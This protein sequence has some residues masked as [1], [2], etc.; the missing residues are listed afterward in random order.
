M[1]VCVRV[2]V[3]GCVC[4][5]C[6]CVRVC[7]CVCVCACVCLCAKH[8]L[9]RYTHTHTHTQ[10]HRI[11]CLSNENKMTAHNLAVVF[12]PTLMRAPS[13]DFLLVKDYPLQHHLVECLILNHHYLFPQT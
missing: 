7:V 4:V 5:C 10:S 12:S 9:I 8:I 1:C 2:C 11:E 3:C 13:D 6:V